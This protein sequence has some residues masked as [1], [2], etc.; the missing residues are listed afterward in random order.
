M[1]P[2]LFLEAQKTVESVHF[3]DALRDY[4]VEIVGKTRNHTLVGLGASPRGSLAI[5]HLSRAKAALAGR[6]YAIPEDV[7]SVA[8]PA[9]SHRLL[10]KSGT[11]LAGTKAEEVIR[12]IL[13][14]TKA[15]RAD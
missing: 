7:K 6:D 3:D 5:M 13:D 10:L 12:G 15:P 11:W 2:E 1:T 9:L 8:A 14:E 4:A